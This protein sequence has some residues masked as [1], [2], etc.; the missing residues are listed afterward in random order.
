MT[1]GLMFNA[2]EILLRSNGLS[3]KDVTLVPRY[4]EINAENPPQL[5]TRITK[6]HLIDLPLLSASM[7]TITEIEMAKKMY[8]L[9]GIGPIHRYMDIEKQVGMIGALKVFNNT[10]HIKTPL[11][12]S[13]GVLE[14]EKLRAEKL[15]D[16][17]VEIILLDI[18]HGDCLALYKVLDFLKAKFP[19]VEVIGGN[20]ATAEGA[21]RMIE[22]GADGV[23]V[24]M[25]VGSL[26]MTRTFTGHGVEPLTAIALANSIASK[27]DIPIIADGGF[28]TTG[29]IIKALSAGASSVMLGSLLAGTDEAP[30]EFT[31]DNTKLYRGMSSLMTQESWIG[32]CRDSLIIEGES[33]MVQSRGPVERIIHEIANGVLTGMS[34][35]GASK[36][37]M[38]CEQALFMQIQPKK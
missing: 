36:V 13:V 25:G 27:Y 2:K 8:S 10:H 4:S 20:V 15:I 30:G 9:G 26:S 12:A 23:K 22:H 31:D 24:G 35:L 5:K 6:K 37:E 1:T 14:S 3:F 19:K 16:A 28:K 17:G 33:R 21:R 32:D 18:A 29:D 11:M 34:F 38:M 7:D